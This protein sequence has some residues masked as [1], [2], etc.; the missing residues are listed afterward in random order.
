MP[1]EAGP[2]TIVELPPLPEVIPSGSGTAGDPCIIASSP[3]RDALAHD[4]P[5]RPDIPLEPA[6]R[7]LELLGLTPQCRNRLFFIDGSEEEDD[8]PEFEPNPHEEEAFEDAQNGLMSPITSDRAFIS[9]TGPHPPTHHQEV[10]SSDTALGPSNV[11][12][13]PSS[14]SESLDPLIPVQPRSFATQSNAS[15]VFRSS[16]PMRKTMADYDNERVARHLQQ[17]TTERIRPSTS[18]DSTAPQPLATP[19]A[20]V[21][22]ELGYSLRSTKAAARARVSS[23]QGTSSTPETPPAGF[24]TW[25]HRLA[26]MRNFSGGDAT[27]KSPQPRSES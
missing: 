21:P 17:L 23:P 14:R 8:Q 26:L 5:H 10:A 24:D 7:T 19:P 22:V 6:A 18:S 2:V 25:G 16:P 27:T 20:P 15:Q 1:C 9:P 11:T 3:A 12:M 4:P 13:T